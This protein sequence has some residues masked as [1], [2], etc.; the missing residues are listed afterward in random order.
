[1]KVTSDHYLDTATRVKYP[2]GPTMSTRRFLVFHFTA[3]ASAKSS[4][5]FW[6]KPEARGAEAHVIVDRDGT[7]Y[8]ILPFNQ[9]ADHAGKSKWRDPKTGRLFENLNSCTI[10]IEMANG[11]ESKTLRER[12]SK[13]P[14]VK[15]R[16]KNGGPVQEWEAY[17]P[18]Q[19]AVAKE[20]AAVL[21]K[22]YNLDDVVGHDDIAP[23]R[24]NDPG[25][26][27][28]MKEVR[29]AAGFSAPLPKL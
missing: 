29:A 24:K 26:A 8:Q 18:E 10:G 21:T 9:R 16:H 3:G 19:I 11:G 13:L 28:P 23:D 22:R 5:E 14:P 7:I 15:A 20:I 27:F 6:R 17:T 4:I 12:Y 1:M 2:A 25:P